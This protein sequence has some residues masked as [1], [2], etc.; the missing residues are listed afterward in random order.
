MNKIEGALTWLKF[1]E[2]QTNVVVSDLSGN[3]RAMLIEARINILEP[4]VFGLETRPF[5]RLH[6]RPLGQPAAV[7]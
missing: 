6:G 5:A 4:R 1:I 2:H 7:F 3:M